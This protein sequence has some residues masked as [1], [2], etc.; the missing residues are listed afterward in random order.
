MS[1]DTP[2]EPFDP[3]TTTR[4][5]RALLN[6]YIIVSLL[7]V[8]GFPFFILPLVFRYHTLRYKF[9]DDGITMSWGVL[10]RREIFLTYRR[11]QDIHVSRGII[12]R[13]LGLATVSVQTASG[14]AGAQMAIEGIGDPQGLRDYLYAKMRGSRGV[15]TQEQAAESE[16]TT[17]QHAESGRD[18]AL[19]LLREILVQVKAM[20]SQRQSGEVTDGSA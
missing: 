1:R 15:S 3:K 4:P 6:Y 10:F 8:V 7:T 20:R 9:D 14:S 2:A 11:I 13:Q 16:T 17:E 12:Q 5:V 18:E 19:E